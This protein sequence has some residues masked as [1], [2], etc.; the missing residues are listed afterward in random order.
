[1]NVVPAYPVGDMPMGQYSRYRALGSAIRNAPAIGAAVGYAA[2]KLHRGYENARSYYTNA[3]GKRVKSMGQNMPSTQRGV[4]LK[5][6]GGNNVVAYRKFR[7]RNRRKKKKTLYGKVK[8]LSKKVHNMAVTRKLS[9]YH[10]RLAEAGEID[11]PINRKQYNVVGGVTRSNIQT[12]GTGGWPVWNP[13]TSAFVSG[14]FEALGANTTV[15]IRSTATFRNN[16]TGDIKIWCYVM[17]CI[18]TTSLSPAGLMNAF[19]AYS[20][21]AIPTTGTAAVPNR[22]VFLSDAKREWGQFWKIVSQSK[23]V[24]LNPG[25]QI[26][27]FYQSKRYRHSSV[28][29]LSDDSFIPGI[30]HIYVVFAEGTAAHDTITESIVGH[31]PANIDY[32]ITKYYKFE[33]NG[34]GPSTTF[35]KFD[36]TGL[37]NV[38]IAEQAH[39]EVEETVIGD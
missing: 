8:R 36:Q 15:S 7:R 22:D 13:A 24:C 28:E 2:G 19:W 38:L 18:A 35:Y 12:V 20:N 9:Y 16:S 17:K 32:V 23:G 34:V 37:G 25:N 26:D 1:M 10:F 3:Y 6:T 27:M 31:G 29:E 30:S 21:G 11:V 39:G 5:G 14:S 33:V 4:T